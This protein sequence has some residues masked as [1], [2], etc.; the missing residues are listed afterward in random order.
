M[1]AI[2]PILVTG[3][4]RRWVLTAAAMAVLSACASKPA[5]R[6]PVVDRSAQPRAAVNAPAVAPPGAENAGKPGYHTVKAGETLTRIAIQY[7]QDRRNIQAWN[8]LSNPD[9]IEVG[10]VLRVVPPQAAVVQGE[11]ASA[12]VVSQAPAAR[13]LP[14]A[15]A[16][17]PAPAPAA[18]PAAAPS[19][20]PAAGAGAGLAGLSLVWPVQGDVL[21]RFDEKTS[22]GIAIGGRLGDPVVAAADGVVA[23]AGSPIRGLGNLV[24]IQHAGGVI[25]AYAHNQTLLVKED[26]QVRQGQRIAEMGSSDSDRVKLHF[27]VRHQGKPVDPLAHLPRR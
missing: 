4:W 11:A 19:A 6:A 2:F 24:I 14:P 18:A 27:E 16:P 26:Q 23:I 8:Q 1:A 17:L 13:P 21:T 15:G 9:L 7:G 20:G 22:R 5:P 3:P 10:Q 25:T 12:P